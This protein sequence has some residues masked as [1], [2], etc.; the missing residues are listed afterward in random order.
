MQW[1]FQASNHQIKIVLLVKFDS[2]HR[3]IVLEKWEEE[4]RDTCPGVT[5][6]RYTAALQPVRRQHISITRD[7]STNPVSYNVTSGAL[8]L[9][10][11]LLLLRDP[12]PTERDIV[13]SVQDLQTYAEKVW[14]RVV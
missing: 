13:I 11:R 12:S 10:F 14:R 8:V 2:T 9:G 3:A 1:W 7:S 4:P 6:T 5:T